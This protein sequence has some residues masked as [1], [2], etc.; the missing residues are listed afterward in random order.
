LN[1]EDT[2]H[3]N[4]IITSSETEAIIKSPNK[5]KAQDRMDSVLN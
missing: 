3:P 5:E 2:K 4:R 1:Q